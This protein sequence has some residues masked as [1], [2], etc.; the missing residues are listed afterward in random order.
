[1]V[2][3][4]LVPERAYCGSAGY[5]VHLLAARLRD[6]HGGQEKLGFAFS[7]EAPLIRLRMIWLA[8][9]HSISFATRRL[10]R[11]D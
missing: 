9:P 3:E 5:G 11:G 7:G 2:L 1:M 8:I 4:P 10:V 6:L